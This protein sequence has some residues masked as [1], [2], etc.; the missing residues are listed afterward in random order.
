MEFIPGDVL[1]LLEMATG[2]SREFAVGDPEGRMCATLDV[3]ERPSAEMAIVRLHSEGSAQLFRVT[4][5][6]V[7]G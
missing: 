2:L 6:P 1:T 3:V 7:E 5:E 4:V